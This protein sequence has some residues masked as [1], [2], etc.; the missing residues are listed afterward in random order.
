MQSNDQNHWTE[1]SIGTLCIIVQ[2]GTKTTS[3]CLLVPSLELFVY[4]Y[5][6]PICSSRS[7]IYILRV[8]Y[9]IYWFTFRASWPRTAWTLALPWL[10]YM[11]ACKWKHF[12]KWMTWLWLLFGGGDIYM[13]RTWLHIHGS[14]YHLYKCHCVLI[15]CITETKPN[16]L[17]L[18]HYFEID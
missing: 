4:I 5:L 11:P 3:F 1:I 9:F 10:H 13:S 2:Y 12:I 14:F 16:H 15:L 18:Y 17:I 8:L 6:Q 7:H